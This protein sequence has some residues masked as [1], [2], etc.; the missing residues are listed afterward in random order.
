VGVCVCKSGGRGWGWGKVVCGCV[1][2]WGGVGGGESVLVE[3][4]ECSLPAAVSRE[5]RAQLVWKA[6]EVATR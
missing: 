4:A 5:V 2:G 1:G 3:G 6:C